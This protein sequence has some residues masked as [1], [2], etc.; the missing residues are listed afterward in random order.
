[1]NK[2]EKYI[3]LDHLPA[4]KLSKTVHLSWTNIQKFSVKVICDIK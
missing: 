2:P 3:K 4:Q 1:M